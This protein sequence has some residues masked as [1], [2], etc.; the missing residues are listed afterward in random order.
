[1]SSSDNSVIYLILGSLSLLTLGTVFNKS[2]P[3]HNE[4]VLQT[5]ND[6]LESDSESDQSESIAGNSSDDYYSEMSQAES[7]DS[8]LSVINARAMGS[9]GPKHRKINNN[10]Y[11][12]SSY[13]TTG[14]DNNLAQVGGQFDINDVTTNYTDR[15]VP[16]DEMEG[17]YA[18]IDIKN[19]KCSDVDKYDAD[20]FLPQQKEKDWF[21]TIETVNVKNSHLINIYRPIGAN[22]IGSSHKGA[23]YDIR[24]RDKAVCPKF[25]VSPWL[26]SSWEP[27]R[28]SKSLCA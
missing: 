9:I 11:K 7:T 2:Y 16:I 26:Q 23:I 15:Y 18:N 17:K 24:G 22:T 10:T 1:M 4:G 6:I 27:D 12:H 19:N 5:K 14:V 28:S 25:V 20:G 8:S 3:I 21:E 13:K